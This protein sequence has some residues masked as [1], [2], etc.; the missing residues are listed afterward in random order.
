MSAKF[1]WHCISVW[2][3]VCYNV[4][5]NV[6]KFFKSYWNQGRANLKNIFVSPYPTLFL[7]H[8][9]VGKIFFLTSQIAYPLNLKL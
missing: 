4:I 2:S 8:G 5:V 6:S 7:R 1:R 3:I 9:S